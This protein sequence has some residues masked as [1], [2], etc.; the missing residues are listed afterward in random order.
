MTYQE[1][2]RRKQQLLVRR[3]L[4]L[5]AAA[6][7]LALLIATPIWIVNAVQN[8]R[9]DDVVEDTL[10][11]ISV[12]TPAEPEPEKIPAVDDSTIAMGS[13]ITANC[14]VLLDMTDG[15][16]VAAKNPHRQANPASIT[17][18]M[19]LLLAVREITDYSETYTMH[20]SF[21]NPLVEAEA[22]RAGFV[23]GE[24]VCMTDLLYGCILPSG[25]DATIALANHLAGGEAA[26][27]AMMNE[28][29]EEL[30]ATNTHFVN[31]S[32]LHDRYHKTTAMDMAL[33]MAAAMKEDQCREVLSARTYTT[34][35]TPQNPEGL[36][37]LST[38]F[39]GLS[40]GD[41]RI[42]AGKTGYTDQ[43]GYTLA[44]YTKGADGHEYVLV[45]LDGTSYESAVGDAHYIYKTY[46]GVQ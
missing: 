20:W 9:A 33:I 39:K 18:V 29:A 32:G 11:Q 21:I 12:Q 34:A 6:A 3:I 22:T 36:P 30:G 10:P 23:T 8:G 38:L 17:K 31:S 13:E 26:F 24:E 37:L 15:R 16:V 1:Y 5:C 35:S 42:M 28:L 43:A 41:T 7:I 19:T 14:A 44:T 2:K 4:L 40:S 46:C 45:T 25:A 27:A